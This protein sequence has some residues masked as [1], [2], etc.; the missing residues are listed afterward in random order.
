MAPNGLR[1]NGFSAFYFWLYPWGICKVSRGGRV[2]SSTTEK[3]KKPLA[4][5]TIACYNKTKILVCLVG[6][7]LEESGKMTLSKALKELSKRSK[8]TYN[9]WGELAGGLSRG[10]ISA[11][12]DRNDAK[13]S[14]LVKL[15][16]AAGYDVLLVR[17]HMLEYEE[18]IV[19]DQAGKRGARLEE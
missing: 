11:P 14:T 5:H 3:N 13:V 4:F 15:A 6:K 2:S 16:N 19:I 7:K 9:S 17:R 10:V 18:P 1:V 8:L 12:I